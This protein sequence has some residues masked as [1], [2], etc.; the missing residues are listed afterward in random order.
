MKM[1]S[2]NAE[3]VNSSQIRKSPLSVMHWMMDATPC[4]CNRAGRML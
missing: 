2:M 4:V 3:K 1:V